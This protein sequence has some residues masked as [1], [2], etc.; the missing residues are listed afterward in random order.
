MFGKEGEKK[1]NLSV[2]LEANPQDWMTS[3]NDAILNGVEIIKVRHL[4]MA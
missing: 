4:F 1:M 2:A 3:Y